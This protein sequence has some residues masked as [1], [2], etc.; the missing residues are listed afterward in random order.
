MTSI[1]L[2]E[3]GL[4]AVKRALV[5]RFPAHKSAHLT[6]ALAA[7]AGFSSH[8]A[9]LTA[10]KEAN[11]GDTGFVLLREAPFLSRLEAVAG[12][13]LKPGDK[14]LLF[15]QLSY[16]ADGG[17]LNTASPH[18]GKIDFSKSAR[19]R[20]WRNAMVAAINAG[21]DQHLFGLRMGDNRWP[22][23]SDDPMQRGHAHVFHFRIGDI[24]ATA[25]VNDAGWDE[26]SIH[27]ALWPTPEAERSVSAAGTGFRI[28]EA[29][30]SGWLE[31][32]DG[33]WL[34]VSEGGPG[35]F[36]CRKPRLATVAALAVEPKGYSD[37]GNFKM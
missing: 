35:H 12:A 14:R 31:R 29:V 4:R 6:E 3:S 1:P 28:G 34:Q 10:I 22:G 24:P 18:Q 37:R 2:N 15:D 30:G 26:L 23:H 8:A 5:E 13:P 32:R 20:A 19:L 11:P 25:S 27:F 36:V 17:I 16:A 21:L 7:A 33:A 9:F